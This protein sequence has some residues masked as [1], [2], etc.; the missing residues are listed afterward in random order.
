MLLVCSPSPARGCHTTVLH[1]EGA[2]VRGSGGV[3]TTVV[4]RHIQGPMSVG[5]ESTIWP[6]LEEGEG[7]E[8]LVGG[9]G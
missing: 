1:A 7:K 2:R 5:P 4:F 6:D 9:K 8:R 3:T